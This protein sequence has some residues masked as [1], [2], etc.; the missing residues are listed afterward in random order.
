MCAD[1][2]S[3]A[4]DKVDLEKRKFLHRMATVMGVVGAAA[5]AVPFISALLP[6]TKAVA[7]GGPVK[8]KIGTM[9]P[10]DQLTVVWR[11]R[12]VW[13]VRRTEQAVKS[14]S[15]LS[16]LLRDPN[17][18][19]DQ[20]PNYAH[21]VYRSRKPEYLVLVGI[22]THLG[23]SPTYRPEP[24]SVDQNWPGGFFCTCHGSKFDLAGRVFKGVPAPINLEVPPYAF[25][26]D[27]EIIIGVDKSLQTV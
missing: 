13:I 10:G 26:N 21:N 14:L 1:D 27:D 6:S 23:C 20:Q 18:E 4:L 8:V 24:A 22:C 7:R 15:D 25:I 2:G 19:V 17:S 3:D 5:A 11:G 12:P 9:K 16:P